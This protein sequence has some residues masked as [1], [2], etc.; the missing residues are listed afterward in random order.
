L[1]QG[2]EFG[3]VLF[4]SAKALRVIDDTTF[5][6]AISVISVSML[7]TPLL[8]QAGATQAFPEAI[9]SSLTL[10]ANALSMVG[11]PVDDVDQLMQG[12][13]KANYNLVRPAA[14]GY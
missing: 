13:R 7:A 8:V 1:A 14:D 11:V 6:F 12:V 5:I 4:S 10:G 3:F 2:G 9:E